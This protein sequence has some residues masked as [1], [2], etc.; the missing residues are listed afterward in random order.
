[1][2]ERLDIPAIHDDDLKTI[3]KKYELLTKFESG[4][5]KCCYCN[6]S[7]TWDNIYGLILKNNIPQLICDSI[8]CLEKSNT[9]DNG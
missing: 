7:L 1:M 5:V 9:I 6:I 8:E 3:L 4:E 2:K